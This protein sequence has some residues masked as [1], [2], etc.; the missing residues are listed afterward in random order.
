MIYT[1]SY[2]FY[3]AVCEDADCDQI[4]SVDDA[5]GNPVCGCHPGYTLNDDGYTCTGMLC[6]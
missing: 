5:T 3:S 4:C 1:I 2:T 6:V